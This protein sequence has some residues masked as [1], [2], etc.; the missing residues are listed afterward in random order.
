MQFP[1]S[2]YGFVFRMVEESDAEF[3]LSLRTNDKLAKHLS[4][5][6]G[7]LD[8][9]IAWIKSYK[10]REARGE[11]YYF[12][13]ESQTGQGLGVIRL[14]NFEGDSYTAGSWLTNPGADEMTAFA[15]DAFAMDLAFDELGFSKCLI[16]VRKQNVKVLRYHKR[17]FKQIAE[18]A[19]NIYMEMDRDGFQRKHQ[20]LNSILQP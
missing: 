9:Q 18:D 2:K 14:Y 12:L 4:P 20:F 1:V 16:D 19:D 13:F 10:Q 11:E 6:E 3:I 15:S 8:G 5:T 17:F 7:D